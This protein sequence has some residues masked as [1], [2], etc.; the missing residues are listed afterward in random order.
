MIISRTPFRISFFGGGTDYPVWYQEHGGAVLGVPSISFAIVLPLLP[1]FFKHRIR[2]VY[3]Q[4]R[5]AKRWTRLFT[6]RCARCCA[7]PASD[8]V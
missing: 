1:P 4:T 6:R 5:I 8:A 7:K 3:S 2:V